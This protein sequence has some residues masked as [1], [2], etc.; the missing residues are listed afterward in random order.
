M[1][2]YKNP[3]W[4]YIFIA[5][6]LVAAV[7]LVLYMNF[8]DGTHYNKTT[9]DAYQEVRDRDYFFTPAFVLFGMSIGLGM[10]GIMELIRKGTKK[11]GAGTNRLAVIASLVLILTPI[12]PVKAN[13]F[14]NDRSN[15][16][17]AYN[18]AYNILKSCDK[19]AILFT[20][21]DNDTFPI[22]CIQEIYGIRQDIRV[23]NFSLLNTDWYSWQLCN[24]DLLSAVNAGYDLDSLARVAEVSA[25]NEPGRMLAE[26]SEFVNSRADQN[27]RAHLEAL[28]DQDELPEGIRMRV[29]I[30]LTDEQIL[31][32]DTAIQGQTIARPSKAFFD[33]VRRRQTFLFPT[34][35]ENRALR[36]ATLMMENIILENKWK[37]PIYFTS[38]SGN[39]RESPLNLPERLV[40]QGFVYRLKREIMN[41]TY[42][43]AKTEELFFQKYSY[44]NLSDT[45]VAQNENA[46]GI[47]LA[48]PEKMLEYQSFIKR[49]GDTVRADSL[50]NKICELIPSYWRSRL[51]QRDMYARSGDSVRA[52]EIENEMMAYLEGY[53]NKNPD[54]IFFY[55]YLGMA[56]FAM[57]DKD[58]AEEYLL[59]AWDLNIDKEHTF[60]SLLTLYAEKRRPADMYR[61]ALEYKQYHDEDN[62]ANE[63][64]RNAQALMQGQT[65][66]QGPTVPPIQIQPTTPPQTPPGASGGGG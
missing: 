1:L 25:S 55:Q 59:D 17:M 41:L 34:M 30:S 20:S 54:N 38:V 66:P 60:R 46:S 52:Q 44:E 31:W 39:V 8:A 32:T 50:L 11:M 23:V 36:V 15:N 3:S 4:G 65:Q 61:V 57:G 16:R 35:Y 22:W 24:L 63:V 28:G 51:A 9:G 58:K 26:P 27:I 18:Y 37:Y 5:L 42:D 56:H 6:V 21:G 12:I 2:A 53:F 29:P 64:I 33:P 45:L 14:A 40:R 10:G 47:A 62:I 19:N 49:K 48:Y 43:E 13:Y 7:G